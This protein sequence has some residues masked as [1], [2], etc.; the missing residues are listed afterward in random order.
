MTETTIL[1]IIYFVSI[2]FSLPSFIALKMNSS[3]VDKFKIKNLPEVLFLSIIPFI[4]TIF[5]LFTIGVT[6]FGG[7]TWLC[8]YIGDKFKYLFPKLS[9][10]INKFLDKDLINF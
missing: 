9:E 6:V 2:L 1:I 7:I 8:I 4:N 5:S 3:K 10:K